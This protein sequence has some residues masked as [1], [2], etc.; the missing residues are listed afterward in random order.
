MKKVCITAM[1]TLCMATYL[2]C[3][4]EIQGSG[5]GYETDPD[6]HYFPLEQEHKLSP[7][8]IEP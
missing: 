4:S 1:L 7:E 6:V 5:I 2:G 8:A 3:K